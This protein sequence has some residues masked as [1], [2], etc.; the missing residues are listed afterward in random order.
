MTDAGIL[1]P[2]SFFR[3]NLGETELKRRTRLY[4]IL[5]PIFILVSVPSPLWLILIPLNYFWDNFILSKSLKDLPERE[6]F[7]SRNAWKI[8]ITGF[9]SDIAGALLLF[10]EM[11]ICGEYFP[12]FS[13][14]IGYGLSMDPFHT[15]ESFLSTL[16][17]VFL[18][19]LL[20]YFIDR[21]ILRRNGLDSALASLASRNLSLLTAPWLFFIPSKWI[22]R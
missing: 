7:C 19:A 12:D 14:R 1:S 21:T 8:C 3:H 16:A 9:L 15:A 10:L 22:Y 18:S 4:N 2:A 5:F 13:D 6:E 17:A 11:L 20:I